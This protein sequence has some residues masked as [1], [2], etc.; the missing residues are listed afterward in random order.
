METSTK[1][2]SRITHGEVL[3]IGGSGVFSEVRKGLVKTL[4][5]NYNPDCK[6]ALPDE[7][8]YDDVGL[9][10]WSKIISTAEF[11]QTA[12]EIAIFENH[13][14]EVAKLLKPEATTI[15]AKP[16][17]TEVTIIDLGAGDT[18]KVEHFLAKVEEA[19]LPAD[20]LALDI[21]KASLDHNIGYLVDKHGRTDSVVK[22]GGLWGT[23]EDG[24]SH[25]E[26][27]KSP[28]L[29]LSLGSV[30]CNDPWPKALEHL[31]DWANLLRSD[32]YLLV[33]MDGHLLPNDR[34]KIWD[35]YHTHDDL[36]ERF[37]LNGFERLNQVAGEDWFKEDDWDIEAELEEEPT[38]RHRFFLRAR[39]D[40]K[41]NNLARVIR[42][43]EEFDWFDSHKYGEQDVGMMCTKAGLRV[44]R[45]YQAPNSEFRQY[46]LRTRR[47]EDG[48]DDADSAVSGLT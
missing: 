16:L 41:M 14:A 13:G 40:I 15:D 45:T 28:R 25:V 6:L 27:I 17:N 43:G 42:K 3:D 47:K 8:L 7:L 19:K 44:V 29:F 23:F 37:F 36:F 48:A 33:G 22:C 34:K 1:P 21:S 2:S 26:S 20:Y 31:K 11:Y 38:T 5:A 32:D 35:A 39:Y 12:D 9:D 46:L 30:L 18:T 4:E 10:I 24:M